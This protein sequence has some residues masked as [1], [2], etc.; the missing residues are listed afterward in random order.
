[1]KRLFKSI[2]MS[3]ALL[4]VATLSVKAQSIPFVMYGISVGSNISTFKL[5]DVANNN[6]SKSQC[7]YQLG[8]MAGLDL[9]IVELT[10]EVLWV[11]SKMEFSSDN[12]T[13]IKSNSVEL[14][15]LASVPILGPLRVKAGP[16]FLLYNDA[17]LTYPSGSE[18][19]DR[20]K[21]TLGYVVGLGLNFTRVTI[22]LRYNGQFTEKETLFSAININNEPSKYDI[23]AHNVSLSVGYR[24]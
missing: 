13:Y 16:S 23:A 18:S 12:S 8:V 3:V 10:A 24:F 9:P 11:N 17:K 1:M 5:Q 20:V 7:G 22:D 14:P 2:V 4:L 21:S 15:I 19:I 6:L